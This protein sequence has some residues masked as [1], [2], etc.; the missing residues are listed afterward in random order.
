MVE[1]F[2]DKSGLFTW[3]LKDQRLRLLDVVCCDENFGVART[4][5]NDVVS[6]AHSFSFLVEH[7]SVFIEDACLSVDDCSGLCEFL[8]LGSGTAEGSCSQ[9]GLAHD[10]G[11]YRVSSN[12]VAIVVV[13]RAACVETV[14]RMILLGL[15]LWS[16]ILS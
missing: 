12:I 9:S 13:L 10:R 8:G 1:L 3:E 4:D 14:L 11:L 15:S 2:Q 16:V 5:L 6:L 7:D